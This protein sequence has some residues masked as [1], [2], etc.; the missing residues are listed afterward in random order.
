MFCLWDPKSWA[1][2]SGIQLKESG[3]LLKIGIQN[4]SSTDKDWNQ[5]PGIRNPTAWN[6]ESMTVFIDSLTWGNWCVMPPLIDERTIV[7]FIESIIYF[8]TFS[9]C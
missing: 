3:I 5:V 1:L 9:N 4:L 7:K 2:E 8:Y 6:P